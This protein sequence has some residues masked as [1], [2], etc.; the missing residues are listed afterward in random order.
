MARQLMN[1]MNTKENVLCS[2]LSRSLFINQ[3]LNADFYNILQTIPN[4]EADKKCKKLKNYIKALPKK[5][6]HYLIYTFTEVV[7]KCHDR[8]GSSLEDNFKKVIFIS[9]D[10]VIQHEMPGIFGILL[11][12]ASPFVISL[13]VDLCFWGYKELSELTHS[14]KLFSPAKTKNDGQHAL[15][16]TALFRAYHHSFPPPLLG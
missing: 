13:L 1:Q 16:T 8:E 3:Q 7:L 11:R 9:L 10:Q 12:I 14:H 2:D 15:G 6:A 5:V 4:A